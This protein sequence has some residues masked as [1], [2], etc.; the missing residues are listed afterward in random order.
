MEANVLGLGF[1]KLVAARDSDLRED[2]ADYDGDNTELL[3][4]YVLAT[5]ND[6]YVYA[7]KLGKVELVRVECVAVI[8]S[9]YETRCYTN[10]VTAY[11]DAE[12]TL[13]MDEQLHDEVF[14]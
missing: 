7:D 11:K 9:D 10:T 6:E 4:C 8:G 14:C 12:G 5:D 2:I 1:L 3:N 13:W